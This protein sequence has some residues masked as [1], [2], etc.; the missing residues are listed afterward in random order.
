MEWSMSSASRLIVL[1]GLIIVAG[2]SERAWAQGTKG[3]G[4]G[5]PPPKNTCGGTG[6]P[7]NPI[8]KVPAADLAKAASTGANRA[9]AATVTVAGERLTIENTPLIRLSDTGGGGGTCPK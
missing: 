1:L 5:D 4:P 3:Q 2:P 8:T 7:G 6:G 9:P